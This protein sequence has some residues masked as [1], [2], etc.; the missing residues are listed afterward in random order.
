MEC[1]QISHSKTYISKE[2]Q[3]GDRIIIRLHFS[4][5]VVFNL[6]PL[7]KFTSNLYF[8]NVLWVYTL[9]QWKCLCACPQ[10]ESH[11]FE[12]NVFLPN[13]C[14]SIIISTVILPRTFVIS[15]FFITVLRINLGGALTR[16]RPLDY[17][18]CDI[19]TRKIRCL[20]FYYYYWVDTSAG[21]R[22]SPVQ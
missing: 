16:R 1:P 15:F 11:W 21:L 14:F 18:P 22:F 13:D 5:L 3:V 4:G 7:F 12:N 8:T 6:D 2:E 19:N 20:R 10:H 9:K 17:T